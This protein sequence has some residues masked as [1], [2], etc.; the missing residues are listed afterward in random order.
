[1]KK[2]SVKEV[3]PKEVKLRDGGICIS[4]GETMWVPFNQMAGMVHDKCKRPSETNE[5]R[6]IVTHPSPIANK[7]DYTPNSG[8]IDRDKTCPKTNES[9]LKEFDEYMTSKWDSHLQMFPEADTSQ[10]NSGFGVAQEMAESFL[11]SSIERARREGAREE[12]ER[13]K[14]VWEQ[15]RLEYAS[16]SLW[17]EMTTVDHFYFLL[18]G[19]E[20]K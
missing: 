11:F 7:S 17:R 18:N 4:C 1:M 6:E 13:I 15:A 19:G 8:A 12:R 2:L 16:K 14:Q 10:W 20:V 9:R 5:K 3:V